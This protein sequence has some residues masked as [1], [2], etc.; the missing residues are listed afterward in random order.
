MKCHLGALLLRAVVLALAGG[1][2]ATAEGENP[3]AVEQVLAGERDRANAAWWGFDAEDATEALQAAID[4]G[5]RKLTVPDMGSP[6]HVEPIELTSS[7][8]TI[9]FEAGVVVKAKAGA[10]QDPRDMLFRAEGI[11][12]LT[13]RGYG[14]TWR[15]RMADYQSDAYEPS[16]WRHG[17]GLFSVQNVKVLG[18]RIEQAGGDGIYVGRAGVYDDR[19]ARESEHCANITIRD[20]VCDNNHRQGISVISVDGLLIEN[21]VLSNTQ[22]TPPAAGIDFEPNNSTDVLVDCVV[23]N[24]RFHGNRRGIFIYLR[25][26]TDQSEP[27]SIVVEDCFISRESVGIDVAAVRDRGPE[28]HI[29]FRNVTVQGVNSRIRDKSAESM[30]VTFEDCTFIEAHLN[31]HASLPIASSVG[32]VEFDNCLF[33]YHQEGAVL[34]GFHRFD[35]D[36][37]AS[38]FEGIRDVVGNIRV[39]KPN[40]DWF[41]WDLPTSNVDIRVNAFDGR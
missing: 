30:K 26:M 28:G 31:M 38:A 1:T 32:K 33:L 7:D 15:M 14:A 19:D 29:V 3:E 41:A 21:S 24:T 40:D 10:F 34:R 35:D 6:W 23:R 36:E 2:M 12:N 27:V 17:L 13:L 18:L 8:Q 25:A 4:S 39:A 11:E 5:V 37:L 9:V 22:G 20:V 16:G